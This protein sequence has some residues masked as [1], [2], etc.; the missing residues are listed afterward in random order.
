[1][2]YYS[3][4]LILNGITYVLCDCGSLSVVENSSNNATVQDTYPVDYT[5]RY[6]CNVGH[7]PDGT[8][9]IVC[10]GGGWL[11]KLRCREVYCPAL[12]P[13]DNG[14]ILD[15]PSYKVGSYI[16]FE[17]REGYELKGNSKLLCRTD[18]QF[19]SSPP[20]CKV[21]M[22]PEFGIVENGRTFQENAGGIENDYG[23]V[24]K[25]TCN[26]G[27][28]LHGTSHMMCQ[29]DGT[30]SNRPTCK[31]ISCPPFKGMDSNCIDKFLLYSTLYYMTCSDAP[32]TRV[33]GT[34][35]DEPNVCQDNGSWQ[36]QEFACYCSC[37]MTSYD[38]NIMKIDN[39]VQEY[40]SHGEMLQWSCNHGC[41]KSTTDDLR[42]QDGVIAMP[43]C[44]CTFTTNMTTSVRKDG[45]FT[46]ST[47][48]RPF[49][50]D[51]T[52]DGK[53]NGN[54]TI[55]PIPHFLTTGTTPDGK[56]DGN[57]TISLKPHPLT[58]DMTSD[59]NM[60]GNITTSLRLHQFTSEMTP[61]GKI[62]GNTT[63][64]LRPHPFTGD[65]TPDGK[66]DGNTTISPIPHPLTTGTTPDGKMDGNTTI[67]L[68][69]HP[70]TSDMT[71]DGNMKGNIT[72]SL[73][74]HQFTSEMT[75]NGKINGNTTTSLRPHPFTGDMTSDGK[76]NGNTTTS[77]IS[78]PFT[79][80]M[81]PGGKIN[82]N[83]P[84]SPRPVAFLVWAIVLI[85]VGVI[86]V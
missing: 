30:W 14:R 23:S 10:G 16:T 68:K 65:M 39:P 36:F 57:T 12:N 26:S 17:C 13:P 69:P 66:M 22:C 35:E 82:G 29:A 4:I 44:D 77:P 32:N 20:V 3:V 78:H 80:D 81:T 40:L 56:M 52:P 64:S 85:G 55:S 70:L 73:R 79:S 41:T 5:V 71:S 28:I 83:S 19:D 18:L 49:S 54:T 47:K 67:S 9:V 2:N 6:K 8:V 76:I 37:N 34:T 53:T 25:V 24:I 61:D 60:K 42:C 33:A 1:M 21:K 63:T 45:H 46:L 48:S 51:M 58:S 86:G 31:G 38:S 74:S 62:N 27:Y 75:P 43:Q 72:T 7:E 15:S 50:T 11:G 84:M 59:G